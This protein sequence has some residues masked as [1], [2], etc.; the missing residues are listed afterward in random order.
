[1][2]TTL[3]GNKKTPTHWFVTQYMCIEDED[4]GEEIEIEVEGEAVDEDSSIGYLFT[5][6]KSSFNNIVEMGVYYRKPTTEWFDYMYDSDIEPFY[7]VVFS[8]DSNGKVKECINATVNK[9]VVANTPN[10]WKTQNVKLKRN[11]IKGEK[12][13]FCFFSELYPYVWN[14]EKNISGEPIFYCYHTY[15]GYIN[16]YTRKKD[17]TDMFFDSAMFPNFTVYG[18]TDNLCVYLQYENEIEVTNYKINIS[19]SSNINST[20]I[21]KRLLKR[22][23]SEYQETT[24]TTQRIQILIKQAKEK[25]I[26]EDLLKRKTKIKKVINS[27]FEIFTNNWLSRIFFR[28]VITTVSF[29]DWLKGKIR[30]TN[31]V[32]TFFCPIDFEIEM[33]SKI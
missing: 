12:I 5:A 25:Y 10:G 2:S 3:I 29:W 6:P 22:R 24:S 9:I 23:T 30:E 26:S 19:D 32:V 33:E 13:L 31:N 27:N 28:T 11:I 15:N 16:K 8:C 20:A 7:P 4:T 1:M 17:Y 18:A 21:Q 14:N